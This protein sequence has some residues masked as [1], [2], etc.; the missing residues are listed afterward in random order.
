MGKNLESQRLSEMFE[1]DCFCHYVQFR[2]E[3]G[4]W[5]VMYDTLTQSAMVFLFI[6]RIT[7]GHFISTIAMIASSMQSISFGS[8][9][10]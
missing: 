5:E 9:S 10:I 6:V 3:H 7:C 8:K 4:G 1:E 2:S